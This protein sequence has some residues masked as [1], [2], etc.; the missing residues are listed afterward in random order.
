MQC[1]G[2][3]RI[4]SRKVKAMDLFT[5]RELKGLLAQQGT[6]CVSLFAPT[7]PGAGQVGT[8]RW[9]N[10]VR[11]ADVQ[12]TAR[13]L[14]PADIHALL[15]PAAAALDDGAF[16]TNQGQGL[17]W[18]LAPGLSKSFWVPV[19]FAEQAITAD[20]FHLKPLV[21]VTAGAAFFVLALS[22]TTVRLFQGSAFG[23]HEID[24]KTLPHGLAAALGFEDQQSSPSA[25]GRDLAVRR[26]GWSALDFHGQGVDTDEK[27]KDILRY[28]Q[29]IDRSLSSYLRGQKAPLVLASVEY[30]W[31][32]YKQANSYA[33]LLAEGVAGH[34][35]RLSAPELHA[36]AWP[37]VR[38]VFAAR[39]R[40][41]V[42]QYHQ[43]AGTGRTCNDLHQVV[44]AA[45]D[46]T[47]QILWVAGDRACWGRW[48]GASPRPKVRAAPE[49]GDED[50]LNLAVWHTLQHRGTV[51]VVP[52][53]DVPGG[54]VAAGIFWLPTRR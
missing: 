21:A 10:L 32:I 23:L 44:R 7:Q 3:D 30:L 42:E 53:A 27:K 28:F 50:L 36:R 17:A 18:F 49:P 9:K 16:W 29:E 2:D 39:P 14:R 34:P 19:A 54:D 20:R 25:H 22:Q 41:A 52:A 33:H 6:T 46:G 48:N 26:G 13:G 15:R 45:T 35:D 24:L 37:L 12:L 51:Y 40:K 47:L 11:E 4:I 5:E 8:I 43:L 38:T 31:P 1:G